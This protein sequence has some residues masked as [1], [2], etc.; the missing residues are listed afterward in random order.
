M[1]VLVAD[2]Q[3]EVRLVVVAALAG[4]EV[5]E[6]RDGREALALLSS[7]TVDVLV[8]D[9]MMPT[10]DGFQVVELVRHDERLRTLPV[11]MLTAKAS[12]TDHVR[13]FLAGADA[14]VIKPF[15]PDDLLLIVCDLSA[16]SPEQRAQLR[17]AELARARLLMQV[18]DSFGP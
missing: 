12:E 17:R 11:V 1:R 2:D 9:V 8:L 14:Y 15:E 16:R 18:E 7:T 3:D 4:M 10:L 5:L 13:A 6:A